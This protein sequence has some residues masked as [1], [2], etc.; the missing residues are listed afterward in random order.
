[1]DA[2]GETIQ[3]WLEQLDMVATVCHWDQPT[4]LVNLVTRLRG[5]AFAFYRTCTP[6]QRGSYKALKAEVV[7]SCSNPV[8]WEIAGVKAKQD[9]DATIVGEK[10]DDDDVKVEKVE[11]KPDLKKDKPK[12]R[13]HT[14]EDKFEKPMVIIIKKVARAQKESE[15]MF[16]NLE[17]KQMKLDEQL[18]NMEDSC[19]REDWE[20]EERQMREEREFHLRM[21]MQEGGM[22]SLGSFFASA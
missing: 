17:E 18:M 11:K 4:K 3:D 13:R 8:R 14:R 6:E 12:K 10:L 21:M 9:R 16:T 5:Q 2:D 1:M 7:H 15:E 22:A 19:W 20:R